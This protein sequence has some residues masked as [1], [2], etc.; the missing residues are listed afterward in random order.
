MK[1]ISLNWTLPELGMDSITGA[2]LKQ[3][4]EAEFGV[5]LTPQDMKNMTF[6]KLYAMKEEKASKHG[7]Y[8]INKVD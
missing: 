8:A 1:T 2:E 5:F 3:I 7:K 4:I 6:G